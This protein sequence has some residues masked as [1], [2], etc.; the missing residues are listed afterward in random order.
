MKVE[1][2]KPQPLKKESFF[3]SFVELIHSKSWEQTISVLIPLFLFPSCFQ[4]KDEK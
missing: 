2:E 1:R 3:S 4:I